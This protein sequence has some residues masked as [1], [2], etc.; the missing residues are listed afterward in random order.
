MPDPSNKGERVV[1]MMWQYDPRDLACHFARYVFALQFCQYKMVLDAAC[2]AGYG[3]QLLSYV[4]KYVTGIDKSRAAIEYAQ[5]HYDGPRTAFVLGDVG[6]LV[7]MDK[8]TVDVAVSFETIE[9]LEKPEAFVEEVAVILKD[10]GI[11]LASAPEN[12][13]SIHHKKDYTKEDLRD[14]LGLAFDMDK[15]R[16][17]CQGPT[18]EIIYDGNPTW[19]HP[20]HIFVCHKGG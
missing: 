11:F 5:D 19:K 14:L 17:Y 1:P 7:W 6:E 18:I 12:S 8:A 4:A 13:G 10:G 2:G 15:A 16:Y 9:H 3:T 20:T